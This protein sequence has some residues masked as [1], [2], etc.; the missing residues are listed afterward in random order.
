MA[1]S[2]TV[3]TLAPGEQPETE[4]EVRR[5][6]F[7]ARAARTDTEQDARAF[8][9][10]VRAAYPDARHHCSALVVPGPG[11]LGAPTTERSSDDGEPA[12]T[13]GQPMLEVLRASTLVGATVVVTRYFGG[14]LLGTGGLVRAYSQATSQVLTAARRVRLATCFLWD[15]RVPVAQAGRL[16][17]E[18]RRL[19]AGTQG[20]CPAS[21]EET[22]WGPT[23]AVLTLTTTQDD[24][25]ALPE[26]VSSLTGGTALLEAAGSR[27]TE[28]PVP[29]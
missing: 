5:S 4:L 9:A 24:G 21:V 29:Q 23:H 6:R 27:L 15:L 10:S 22:V 16:E 19:C 7:L 28:L 26:I 8:I 12:G 3:L 20:P 13:A 14:V 2:P 1:T 25:G 18:L 11:G 17:S